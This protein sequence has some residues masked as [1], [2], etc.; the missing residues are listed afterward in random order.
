MEWFLIQ[1][2]RFWLWLQKKYP[3]AYN[4]LRRDGKVR[5]IM[6]EVLAWSALGM[7]AA[8]LIVSIVNIVAL[9]SK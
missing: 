3:V 9:L 4:V 1:E 7:S 6:R 2:L 5:P 8:S